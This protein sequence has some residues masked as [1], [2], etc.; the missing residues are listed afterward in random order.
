M[1]YFGPTLVDICV[2]RGDSPVIPVSVKDENGVAIDITGGV[3]TL[4]IDGEEEPTD[5]LNNVFSVPGVIT[6]AP[7]GKVTFTPST[8][9]TDEGSGGYFY[10]IQM[11]LAGSTR[12]ILKGKFEILQDI[13]KA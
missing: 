11:V 4:T 8:T 13:T 3:F 9:D 2:V 5:A 6:D 1:A 12:T 10:D 7:G